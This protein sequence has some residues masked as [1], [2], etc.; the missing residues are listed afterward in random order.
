MKN[1]EIMISVQFNF[2]NDSNKYSEKFSG[3]T[4]SLAFL[5]KDD[6]TLKAFIEGLYY[7]LHNNFPEHFILFKDYLKHRKQ[8]VVDYSRKGKYKVINFEKELLSEKVTLIELGFVTSSVLVITMKRKLESQLLF[9]K[10]PS[11]YILDSDDNPLEYNISSRTLEA[12]DSSD[13]EILPPG[14]IPEKDERTLG[15]ILI[16][17]VLSTGGMI[18]VRAVMSKSASSSGMG[19][20]M[21]MMTAATGVMT[22]VTST[23]NYFKQGAT[24]TKKKT[25][26]KENYEKYIKRL[27]DEKIGIWQKADLTYLQSLYPDMLKLFAQLSTLDS[28]IFSRSQNDN[29][30]MRITL[31]VSEHVKPLFD[32]KYCLLYTSPSPRD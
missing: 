12:V 13:I 32:I 1:N 11:S 8:F 2:P 31:G 30:F 23:Y 17:T 26:W 25:E 21:W 3:I 14:D 5:V 7:G 20:M 9:D 4:D 24:N 27:I 29:D 15:D 18:G 16:P 19:G 6:I 10:I 22:L 28:A